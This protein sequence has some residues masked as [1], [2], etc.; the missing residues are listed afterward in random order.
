[1]TNSTQIALKY[2]FEQTLD[3][4]WSYLEFNK[5][6]IEYLKTKEKEDYIFNRQEEL[7]ER[8]LEGFIN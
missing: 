1:M 3:D 6:Y 4:I 7:I 8:E 5:E 2:D